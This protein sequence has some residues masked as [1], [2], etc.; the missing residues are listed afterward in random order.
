MTRYVIPALLAAAVVLS[1]CGLGPATDVAVRQLVDQGIISMENAL[2]NTQAKHAEEME[3]LSQDA[4]GVTAVYERSIAD[5]SFVVEVKGEDGKKKEV[6]V[7]QSDVARMSHTNYEEMMRLV[8]NNMDKARQ[9]Q[10]VQQGNL[11]A[12]ILALGEAKTLL[13]EASDLSLTAKQYIDVLEKSLQ[14]SR[15]EQSPAM[16]AYR[17]SGGT[18]PSEVVDVSSAATG[19]S[20]NGVIGVPVVVDAGPAE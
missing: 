18:F 2:Y 20:G 3:L 11:S 12:G 1:G 14:R 9:D 5:N 10:L 7:V 4:K 17:E 6:V 16:A 8:R 19:N 13:L 15:R